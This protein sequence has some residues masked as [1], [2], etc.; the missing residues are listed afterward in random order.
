[1]R[2]EPE[3]ERERNA[4]HNVG[5]RERGGALKAEHDRSTS[6]DEQV[7]LK[8]KQGGPATPAP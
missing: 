7:L 5:Y 2:G 8:M 4:R 3:R 1:M 6:D